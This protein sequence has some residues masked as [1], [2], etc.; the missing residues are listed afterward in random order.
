M[1]GAWRCSVACQ[2]GAV[3]VS[4]AMGS[5]RLIFGIRG[6]IPWLTAH[7]HSRKAPEESRPVWTNSL[8]Q[9]Q[10]DSGVFI[11]SELSPAAQPFTLDTAPDTNPGTGDS[12]AHLR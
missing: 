8:T 1:T 12:D 3:I 10:V 11:Q 9:A 2:V 6:R 7:L 5:R 4:V